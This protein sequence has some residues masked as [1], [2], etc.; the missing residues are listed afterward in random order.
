MDDAAAQAVLRAVLRV[1]GRFRRCLRRF[2][3]QGPR[4]VHHQ[5][6]Q[7][8]RLRADVLPCASAD[9]LRGGRLRRRRL[10]ARQVRHPDR[11]AA[12]G[13][14]GGGERLDRRLDRR[15]D[16]PRHRDGRRL[17]Q[18]AC[19]R[20]PAE[21]RFPHHRHRSRDPDRSGAVRDR[22]RLSDRRHLQPAH[23]RHR[24][25][26]CA[27]GAQPGAT[28][29]RFRRLLHQ[30]VARQAGPDL[31]G[32]HHAVLGR[33]RHPAVHR[34]EMG[35]ELARHAARPAPPCC[36]AWSRSASRSA[37]PPPPASCR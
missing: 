36:R 9:C 29:R 8:G 7:G 30:A 19:G 5:P 14:T 15:L 22:R 24:R 1:A 18:S 3:A 11:T 23:S 31:A 6:D 17:D 2:A 21:I 25:P 13:K 35:G 34:A 26:L 32:G 33:R 10:F 20:D 12:A 27:S 37:R 28:D 4:H 16:H